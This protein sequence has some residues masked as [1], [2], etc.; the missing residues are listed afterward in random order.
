MNH[1]HFS[2]SNAVA[3]VS[4]YERYFGFQKIKKLGGT[5]VLKDRGN[6][7]LA[8]DEVDKATP[9][10]AGSHLGFTLIGADAVQRL[11]EEM[12]K[13]EVPLN[14]ELQNPSARAIHFYCLD[15][16]RNRVEVGWYEW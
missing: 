7:I 10:P 16:S 2:S 13:D 15:P 4:F 12:A 8:I 5:H 1:F 3:T 6:F 14:G 11:Y 9:I